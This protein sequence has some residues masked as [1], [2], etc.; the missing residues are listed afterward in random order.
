M[1]ATRSRHD[2]YDRE[3]WDTG[4]GKEEAGATLTLISPG[5]APITSPVR[6][7]VK[8]KLGR[9]C[10]NTVL[11]AQRGYERGQLIIGQGGVTCASLARAASMSRCPRQRAGFSP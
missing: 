9:A 2:L 5:D 4:Q 10:R 3:G 6:A 11:G 7:A 1:R 8:S